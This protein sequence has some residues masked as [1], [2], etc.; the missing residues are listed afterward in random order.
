MKTKSCKA[1]GRRLQNHIAET[2]RNVFKL[3][4]N[5]VKG[6]TMGDTGMDIQLSDKA[7]SKFPYGVEAKSHKAMAIYKHWEQAC[8]NTEGLEPLLV[9]KANNKKPLAVID[10]NHFIKLVRTNGK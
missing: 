3:S 4:K 5:D 6:T 7:R 9:V 1:K 10:L 2:I 8:A